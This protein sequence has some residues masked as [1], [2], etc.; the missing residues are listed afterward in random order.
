[1]D[2][3]LE[4]LLR[5]NPSLEDYLY[6]AEQLRSEAKHFSAQRVLQTAIE[7]LTLSDR[8]PLVDEF[9]SK[10]NE[11]KS[12]IQE[13]KSITTHCKE[14]LFWVY[15]SL[16]D[17]SLYEG[18]VVEAFQYLLAA[19]SNYPKDSDLNKSLLVNVV[20]SGVLECLLRLLYEELYR[21][22]LSLMKFWTET[23]QWVISWIKHSEEYLFKDDKISL[24][25]GNFYF[26]QFTWYGNSRDLSEAKDHLQSV[27]NQEAQVVVSYYEDKETAKLNLKE[28]IKKQPNVSILWTWLGIMEEDF[29]RQYN[30]ITRALELDKKNW[31]AWVALGLLQASQGDFEASAKTWKLAQSIN[32]LDSK[33]WLL[34]AFL[35]HEAKNLAR[36]K[37][38]L[39]MACDLEPS[40]CIHISPQLFQ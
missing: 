19:Y 32:Y 35:A 29:T 38:S 11:A 37:E 22:Q 12:S 23:I 33:L 34:S 5:G 25:I 18:Q 20:Y 7:N 17:I 4:E 1:M 31:V 9:T 6:V 15:C 36:S 27:R 39:K 2:S 10:L 24:S 3:R 14:G 16:G 8:S 28:L 30:A 21:K 40:L 26:T 13:F